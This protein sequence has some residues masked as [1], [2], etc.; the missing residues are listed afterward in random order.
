MSLWLPESAKNDRV[1][2]DWFTLLLKDVDNSLVVYFNP[3]KDRWVINR[4][5]E[6]GSFHHILMV[7]GDNSDYAPL[8]ERVIAKL[9]EMDTWEKYGT[10]ENFHLANE[11]ILAEQNAKNDAKV[12][13]TYDHCAKIN[14][15]QLN[16]AHTLMQRHDMSEIH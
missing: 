16:E 9:K 4:K 15:R 12:D 5:A 14:R 11:N 13:D 3:W 2:P 6:D 8:N 7:E 10:V 1:V